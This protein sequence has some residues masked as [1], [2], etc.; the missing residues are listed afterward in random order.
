M[1]ANYLALTLPLIFAQNIIS[2]VA[3]IID[4]VIVTVPKMCYIL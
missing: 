3:A 1:N 2:A 4:N